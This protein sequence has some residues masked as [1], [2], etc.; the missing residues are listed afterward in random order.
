MK[1]IESDVEWAKRQLAADAPVS[2]PKG[3][4]EEEIRA[5]VQ[6]GLSRNEAIE[7]I[8]RQAAHDAAQSKSSDGQKTEG[9]NAK[10]SK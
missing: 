3:I 4:S 10:G 1:E 7:V 2:A 6:A 8:E 9:K 5:K